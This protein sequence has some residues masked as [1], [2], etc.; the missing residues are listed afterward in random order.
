MGG[1]LKVATRANGGSHSKKREMAGRLCNEC[2]VLSLRLAPGHD[3]VITNCL[4][5]FVDEVEVK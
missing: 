2:T 4:F 1:E 3:G 5:V